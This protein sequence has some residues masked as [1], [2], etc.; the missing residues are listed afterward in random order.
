MV[1]EARLGY[2]LGKM[3]CHHRCGD[4]RC[5]NPDH[6]QPVTNADNAAEMLARKF[7]KGRIAELEKA[8]G[9][10]QPDHILLLPRA[11]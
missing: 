8:L 6:L 1:L 5:I 7:Y 3:A 11:A 2:A 10:I 4:S 9:A